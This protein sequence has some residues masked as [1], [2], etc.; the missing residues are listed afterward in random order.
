LERLIKSKKAAGRKKDLNLIEELKALLEIQKR[1][2][3]K[4]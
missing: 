3:N 4:S 1:E 2:K